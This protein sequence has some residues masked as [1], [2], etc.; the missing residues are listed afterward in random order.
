MSQLR[1]IGGLTFVNAV[2]LGVTVLDSIVTAQ[3]F[4]TTAPMSNYFAAITVLMIVQKIFMVGQFSD[5]FLPQY[6][7]IRETEGSEKADRCFSALFNHIMLALM[8]A[9][10]VF[11]VTASSMAK[12]IAPGFSPEAQVQVAWF[13]IGLIP[14]VLLT[15]ANGHLYIVGNAR[16]WYSRFAI[17]GV[18]GNALGLVA[19][20][21][22]ARWVGVWAV[23]LS[24]NVTQVVMLWGSLRYL[25]RNGYR[26]AWILREPGFSTW[27]VT[28]RVGVTAIYVLA[29]QWYVIGFNAALTYLPNGALAVY[30]YAE[31]LYVKSGS[32]FMRPVSVVF[33]TD[34]SVLA[35]RDPGQLRARISH[36]L[37][38]YALL[39][40]AMVAVLLP[41]IPNLLGALWGGANYSKADIVQTVYY[42]SCLYGLLIVDFTGQTYRRLNMVV[43]DVLPQYLAMS[44][45][46]V[47]SGF[48]APWIV[49]HLQVNGVPV[50]LVFNVSALFL[51][52]IFVHACR[53][54]WQLAF[55]PRQTWKLIVAA[56]LSLSMAWLMPS[57][58]PWL[59]YAGDISLSG[60]ILELMKSALMGGLGLSLLLGAVFLLKVE[61]A[62]A[63]WRWVREFL[64][65]KWNGLKATG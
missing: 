61:E 46:Q 2:G 64:Q 23:V 33:F 62:H 14:G 12:L 21:A 1:S 45:A 27:S 29:T 31:L 19:M 22:T 39:F 24:Q 7:K 17:Y 3:C 44:V 60:K 9:G 52:A 32:L 25:S 30:K 41:A 57:W 51:S 53:P 15:V 49:H 58:L 38:H 4:G 54:Q 59:Q 48:A 47:L 18:L 55:F 20:V 63:A 37:Y 6:V 36:A 42:V 5:V 65:Q 56:V 40:A 8:F 43:G 13:S 11:V 10:V 34:A 16:G 26:H 28:A 50:V 35:H